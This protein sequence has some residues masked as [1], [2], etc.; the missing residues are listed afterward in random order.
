MTDLRD[1]FERRAVWQRE[2]AAL[3]W[4]EKIR[5]AEALREVAA[6]LRRAGPPMTAGISTP[7]QPA[8][9]EGQPPRSLKDRSLKDK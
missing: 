7:K 9:G 1:L 5:M 3:S 8:G 2:R 6:Q 4:P